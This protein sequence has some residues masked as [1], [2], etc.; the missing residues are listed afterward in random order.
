MNKLWYEKYRPKTFDDLFLPH[1]VAKTCRTWIENFGKKVPNTPP[2]LFI[3][4]PPGIGKTSMAKILLETYGYEVMEFNASEIRNASQI[5]SKIEEINGRQDITS[6]MCFKKRNIAIIMDEIDGMSSGDRGGL[7]ELIDII[8]PKKKVCG[9]NSKNGNI[10]EFPKS[11]FICITNTID[12]KMKLLRTKSCDIRMYEPEKKQLFRIAVY[13]CEQ[14]KVDFSEEMLL[15]ILPHAQGDYR[16]LINILEYICIDCMNR[17]D[18]IEWITNAIEHFDKKNKHMDCYQTTE[19]ILLNNL[20]HEE[21]L[22]YENKDSSMTKMLIEENALPHIIKNK[23]TDPQKAKYISEL[24]DSFSDAAI[25]EI[26]VYSQQAWEMLEYSSYYKTVKANEI[27]TRRLKPYPFHKYKEINHSVKLNKNSHEMIFKKNRDEIMLC[28]DRGSADNMLPSYSNIIMSMLSYGK[29]RDVVDFCN[30]SGISWDDF[31]KKIS[32][33]TD[34]DI[35]DVYT[36]AIKK[37]LKKQ[38]IT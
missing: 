22:Y 27:L 36:S 19:K 25:Y 29:I 13:I 2:C 34:I 1:T 18:T 35:K 16:R 38:F 24:Y 21:C 32:K 11:P 6:I 12:K 8:F 17:G 5:R 30:E 37:T 28:F 31:D 3:H 10:T 9:K 26:T 15:H 23:K 33:Y 4:G 14:E 7:S 20:T